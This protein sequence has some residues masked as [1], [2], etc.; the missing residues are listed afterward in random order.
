LSAERVLELV[1][2]VTGATPD[3][4]LQVVRGPRAIPARRFAVWS[5]RSL[6]LMTQ[7]QIADML[8]TTEVQVSNVIR[9]IDPMEA[10]MSLW[11]TEM[12]LLLYDK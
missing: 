11:H 12:Q 10:T 1:C 5:L 7:K 4:L 2:A 6:T 8:G 9:R 3:E